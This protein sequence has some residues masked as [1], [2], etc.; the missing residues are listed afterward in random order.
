MTIVDGIQVHGENVFFGIVAVKLRSQHN[1]FQFA[2]NGGCIAYNEIFDQLLANSAAPLDDTPVLEIRSEGANNA[3]QVNAG[4]L[5]EILI[6]R[7]NGGIKQ[8]GRDLV[9]DDGC[10]Q[11]LVRHLVKQNTLAIINSQIIGRQQIMNGQQLIII[12]FLCRRDKFIC[13]IRH[14]AT[15]REKNEQQ[16]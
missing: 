8:V 10:V 7:S 3:Q 2:H 11:S 15:Y 4:I 6:L 1:L 13:H 5:P 14:S 12:V 9:K 16:R